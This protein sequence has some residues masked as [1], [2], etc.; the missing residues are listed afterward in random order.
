M[1]YQKLPKLPTLLSIGGFSVRRTIRNE[2]DN[3]N[4]LTDLDG[5]VK[6]FQILGFKT[7]DRKSPLIHTGHGNG[8]QHSA[9][10]V[11]LAC[12]QKQDLR[13]IV[14][15]DSFQRLLRVSVVL[16]SIQLF[17]PRYVSGIMLHSRETLYWWILHPSRICY[18]ADSNIPECS[19]C[20]NES[21][22]STP[23]I[24][25]HVGGHRSKV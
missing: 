5:L 17:W 11:Q 15:Y 14:S 8:Y 2:T 4:L 24:N 6:W 1:D 21:Y 16:L 13:V 9:N 19:V 22:P 12:V 7:N 18:I 20:R 23:W 3:R 10:R 25:N